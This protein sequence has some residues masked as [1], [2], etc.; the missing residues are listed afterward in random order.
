MVNSIIDNSYTIVRLTFNWPDS[1]LSKGVGGSL[2]YAPCL[3]EDSS[4]SFNSRSLG[5]Q[6][7]HDTSYGC[8]C[9]TLNSPSAYCSSINTQSIVTQLSASSANSFLSQFPML[10][11]SSHT[12]TTSHHSANCLTLWPPSIEVSPLRSYFH[13][14]PLS[15]NSSIML[16]ITQQC[17]KAFARNLIKQCSISLATSFHLCSSF[18]STLLLYQFLLLFLAISLAQPLIQCSLHVHS[19]DYIITMWFNQV[20]FTLVFYPSLTLAVLLLLPLITC[21]HSHSILNYFLTQSPQI[22]I[23]TVDSSTTF[24][25][26]QL[27]LLIINNVLPHQT[28][29]R[30][31]YGVYFREK[32][33]YKSRLI[34][35]RRETNQSFYNVLKLSKKCL[36]S[37][38]SPTLLAWRRG[39]EDDS[40]NNRQLRP[41]MAMKIVITKLLRLLFTY[42]HP[43]GWTSSFFFLTISL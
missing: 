39:K 22:V 19:S 2:G 43:P 37:S 14:I 21:S 41:S 29:F 36:A 23:H 9:Y 18:L 1:Y 10:I 28:I 4:T 32:L 15:W 30:N 33:N 24:S 38:S 34:T 35:E 16:Q 11:K 7:L 20:Q 6:Y 26:P 5:F 40:Y 25:F 27:I 8:T 12:Q 42:S 17:S 3:L 13:S 31:H